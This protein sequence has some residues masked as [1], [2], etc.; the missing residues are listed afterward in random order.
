MMKAKTKQNHKIFLTGIIFFSVFLSLFV[1]ESKKADAATGACIYVRDG[2]EVT[3]ISGKSQADCDA[4]CS[5]LEYKKDCA[6]GSVNFIFKENTTPEKETKAIITRSKA[7]ATN[8]CSLWAVSTWPVC[9][10]T[11]VLFFVKILFL[12][13]ATFLGWIIEPDN[14]NLVLNGQGVVYEMWTL[15]RNILNIAFILVLLFSAFCTI[16]QIDK[17]NYKKILLMLVIMALLVNFSY[18]IARVIIDASNV[19]MYSLLNNSGF[20]SPSENSLFIT[21]ITDKTSLGT[22]FNS[23]T[24]IKSGA[25]T[26]LVAIVFL[27]MLAIT[28]LVFAILLFIRMM[29]LAFLIIFSPI[30]FIGNIMPGF[31]SFA[32]KWWDN[33]FKYAFFGPI[34]ILGLNIS[35]KFMEKISKLG[36]FDTMASEVTTKVEPNFI[37][38]VA[39]MFVP[40][41][42]LWMT[43]GI[44]QSMSIAGAGAVMGKAQGFLKGAGKF[45]GKYLTGI[46]PG[47]GKLEREVAKTKYGKFLVPRVYK[48]AWKERAAMKDREAFEGSVGQMHDIFNRSL[49]FGKEKSDSAFASHEGKVSKY[50]KEIA[51][52]S[53]SSGYVIEE[54]KRAIKNKQLAKVEAAIKVLAKENNLNDM[55]EAIGMEYGNKTTTASATD[56]KSALADIL[57]KS[58]AGPNKK[59]NQL[60]AKQLM[61]IGDVSVGAGNIAF[62]GMADFDQK[63]KKFMIASDEEQAKAVAG[64]FSNFEAQFRQ[65]MT[66][67]NSIL[68]I[69]PSGKIE[70]IDLMQQSILRNIDASDIDQMNRNRKDLRKAVATMENDEDVSDD[71]RKIWKK[72]KQD[73]PFLAQYAKT[74]AEGKAKPKA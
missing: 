26:M 57:S 37:G 55:M 1:F 6:S 33:L 13:A 63:E 27:F 45:S 47:L 48:E 50:S 72:L 4:Y 40:L 64:K 58:G 69:A 68:G 2:K 24:Y 73:N 49:S 25:G 31:Q 41:V 14:L 52:V 7:S 42:L 44:A 23:D 10:L 17:Y 36:S 16:F 43:M 61:G 9:F 59:D 39:F 35:I 65:R 21:Q 32:S 67:P 71:A 3:A 46:K 74:I 70:K 54:L 30:G 19:L 60:L 62:N 15:V 51:D 28:L 18:P 56:I 8:T 53:D 11:P 66:H 29:V 20:P 38:G 12:G 34:M 22:L 5:R